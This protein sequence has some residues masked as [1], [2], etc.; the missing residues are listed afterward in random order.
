MAHLVLE[1]GRAVLVQY[2]GERH[3]HRRVLLCRGNKEAMKAITEEDT[4]DAN[5]YMM[6][7]PEIW[8]VL[9]PDNH[10]YPEEISVPPLRAF[11]LCKPDGALEKSTLVGR[12]SRV[13]D[14]HDFRESPS[15][16]QFIRLVQEAREQQ[17]KFKTP[18]AD[19]KA[20]GADPLP[21]APRDS[22]IPRLGDEETAAQKRIDEVNSEVDESL[23]A[24]VL[25]MV[26][27]PDGTRYKDFR[28]AVGELLES[29]WAG[30]PLSG[31]RTT[32]WCLRYIMEVDGHPT[33]HHTRWKFQAGLS[34]NDLGVADHE[35]AMKIIE[36]SLTF[37]QINISEL[38]GY[39][40]LLRKA[41]LIELKYKQ[42]SLRSGGG[43]DASLE[44]E[45][46]YLGMHATRGQLM[47]CPELETF[48]AAEMAKE[49]QVMKEKRKLKEEKKL[50][51]G[52]GKGKGKKEERTGTAE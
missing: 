14:I 21:A 45:H 22:G 31:P 26:R 32:R 50:A 10:I 16:M 1:C 52:E 46:L 5:S 38:A 43:L 35:T 20:F 6:T 28:K 3:F 19:L 49:G 36:Y 12:R 11:G 4:A 40:L 30:W 13:N 27:L 37:D 33:A 29:P 23:D 41:Q 9:T 2:E 15:P 18:L 24:R 7:D 34:G 42:R 8:W 47:I 39:E 25:S 44:D 48:V 17:K 51:K